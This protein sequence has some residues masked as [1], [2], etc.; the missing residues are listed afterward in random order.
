MLTEHQHLWVM[1]LSL[2]HRRAF[3]AEIPK[4]SSTKS[5]TGHSL[6]ATGAQETIYSLLMMNNNFISGSSNIHNDD[7]NI[8]TSFLRQKMISR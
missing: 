7:P 1:K 3:G 6:G 5:L 8:G 4:I 2:G